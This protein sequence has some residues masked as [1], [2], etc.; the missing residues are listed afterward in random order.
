MI[1]TLVLGWI[2]LLVLTSVDGLAVGIAVDGSM[3]PAF[4]GAITKSGG[5]Y[6]IK[7]DFGKTVGTN[8]F[9]SFGNFSLTTGETADFQGSN[10]VNIVA[11]VTGKA[12]SDINGTLKSSAA[13]A[14]LYLMNPNG[15]LFG[16]NASLDLSGSFHV[17]TAD[18]IKLGDNDRFY[19]NQTT[20]SQLVAFNPSAFGFLSAK[21]AAIGAFGS[22]AINQ[23]NALPF[24]GKGMR[25]ANGQTLS[26]VG[27][28]ILITSF[29]VNS[30]VRETVFQAPGGRINL[31]SVASPGEVMSNQT[32]LQLGSGQ[33]G[34]DI[35]VDGGSIL[36]ATSGQLLVRGGSMTLVNA[37]L[38]AG[39]TD[40][41]GG[42]MIDMRL[43][44]NLTLTSGTRVQSNNEGKGNGGS[45]TITTLG[46]VTVA[47]ENNAYSSTIQ[48]GSLATKA[49]AGPAGTIQ[50]NVANL[51]VK[52]GGWIMAN[53]YGPGQGGSI[54]ITSRNDVTVAGENSKKS[55]S[56]IQT[57]SLGTLSGA[58]AGGEISLNVANLIMEEGGAINANTLGLGHGGAIH[59]TA[60]EKVQLSGEGQQGVA[61]TIQAHSRGTMNQA[62][63]GG[64]ITLNVAHLLLL[65]GGGIAADT[66]GPGH[67]G[68]INITASEDVSVIGTGPKGTR[69]TIQTSSASSG[70]AGTITLN[71]ANLTVQEGAVIASDLFDVGPGGWIDITAAKNV[72]VAGSSTQGLQSS[73]QSQ[74]VGKMSGAGAGGDVKMKVG[75]LS[76]LDGGGIRVSTSGKGRG[77]SIDIAAT[78]DVNIVGQDLVT[79]Y[80]SMI[81]AMSLGTMSGSGLGGDI[82]LN[83]KNL[84]L[85]NGGMI[86]VAT[87]GEGPSGS[88]F[89][90]AQDVTLS[91]QIKQF[92]SS[93][94]AASQGTLA[95][96]G[97]A[98]RIDLSVDTLT[99][100]PGTALSVIT[101]GGGAGGNIEITT[102]Q[103]HLTGGFIFAD[104]VSS[105]VWA[106]KGGS[107]RVT[108]SEQLDLA[109]KTL[110]STTSDGAQGGD[111]IM[112]APILSVTGGSKIMASV[113]GRSGAGGHVMLDLNTL[114]LANESQVVST[115]WG[116]GIGG[117]ITLQADNTWIQS[118]STIATNSISLAKNAGQAGAIK[119]VSKDQLILDEGS[120]QS[121]A[122]KGGGG[123]ITVQVNNRIM[124]TH[125][126][127]AT[128]VQGGDGKGGNVA[129]DPIHLILKGSRIEANAFQGAGGNVVI[130]A[131][132]LLKDPSS[133]IT[134]SSASGVQGRVT[135]DTPHV[136][137][138]DALSV[139]PMTFFDASSLMHDRCSTRRAGSESSF[140]LK[141][142]G[143][144]PMMPW[145]L[146][147][148]HGMT[149]QDQ[150]IESGETG[151]SFSSVD[152]QG[153]HDARC[154]M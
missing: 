120:I 136:T 29:N 14:N 18:Y 99:M 7:Q 128:S 154:L 85:L 111:I 117:V 49:E 114:L 107:I 22:G 11:R 87:G 140:I 43:Q 146:L 31:A 80:P 54:T 64:E 141:G 60:R 134:A 13:G 109:Q 88:V 2:A 20:Q 147:A 46:D 24:S 45:I 153:N 41:R 90:H 103:A 12:L 138:L 127:I 78:G 65:A 35:T 106:G 9:H 36:N 48:A 47:G 129:I 19:A 37:K 149:V 130:R 17:T 34:A 44:G 82:H 124:L 23:T 86:S 55:T 144:L 57:A 67:G 121:M 83:V 93:I 112:R 10:I 145:D 21:P 6:A 63:A 50:L 42:G 72:T 143:A 133:R 108:A 148:S 150:G 79:E 28:S 95:S 68:S 105:E 59:V 142:R 32:D 66:M 69:S 101:A 61:T 125:S 52:E 110:V 81:E 3:N 151:F 135:L 122:S 75:N 102:R 152:L 62:G 116:L 94:H 38:S 115:T 113:L 56:S 39:A 77:G 123:D 96:S 33:V 97:S 70:A 89:I 40:D 91:G 132:A 27:G 100:H 131:E 51:S 30:S 4:S 76:L 71:L 8:L 5:V 73:I 137:A 119:L 139:L 104:T 15:V 118:G 1:K 74:T 92:M 84:S 126:D 98:G 25:V 58:G 16:P 53:T 26:A